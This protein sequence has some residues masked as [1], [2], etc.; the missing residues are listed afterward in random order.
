MAHCL[1]SSKMTWCHLDIFTRIVHKFIGLL[2]NGHSTKR[3]INTVSLLV[4]LQI[5]LLILSWTFFH[6]V[7]SH[8]WMVRK[9]EDSISIYKIQHFKSMKLYS[10]ETLPKISCINWVLSLQYFCSCN[11]IPLHSLAWNGK[12]HMEAF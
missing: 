4:M 1:V 9:L 3:E 10:R 7:F 5:I 11:G 6:G 2:F 12:C 8:N